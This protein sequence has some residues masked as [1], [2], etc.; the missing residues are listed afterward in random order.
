M[1]KEPEN[2]REVTRKKLE[3]IYNFHSAHQIQSSNSMSES[4]SELQ[5]K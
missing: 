5:Y 2:D 3:P 1:R 4:D